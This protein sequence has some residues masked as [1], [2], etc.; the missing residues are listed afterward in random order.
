M[1][2]DSLGLLEYLAQELHSTMLSDLRNPALR[3]SLLQLIRQI[4]P[5]LY[6]CAE[7]QDALCYLLL[8]PPYHPPLD[9]PFF[10]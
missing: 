9:N 3:A 4:P 10:G 1:Q 8:P 2:P 6:T 7:W 5:E